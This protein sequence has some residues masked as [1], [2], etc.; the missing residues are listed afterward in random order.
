M[1]IHIRIRNEYEISTNEGGGGGG[2][3][4]NCLYEYIKGISRDS[5]FAEEVHEGV[6][7]S[8]IWICKTTKNDYR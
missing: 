2:A 3:I 8:V 5:D 7:K 4:F 6:G 1:K